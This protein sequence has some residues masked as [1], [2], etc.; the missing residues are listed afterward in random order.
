MNH[1]FN[2]TL[3]DGPH[4]KDSHAHSPLWMVRQEPLLNELVL[5]L[6][7]VRKELEQEPDRT[8][9]MRFS[10]SHL[11]TCR[12]AFDRMIIKQLELTFNKYLRHQSDGMWLMDDFNELDFLSDNKK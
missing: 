5:Y 6:D 7:T 3:V 4:S 2:E 10:R 11:R 1:P 12:A 8:H 9:E